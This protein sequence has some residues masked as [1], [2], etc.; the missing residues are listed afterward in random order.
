MPF[1][2]G[3]GFGKKDS[4]TPFA[5]FAY[6]KNWVAAPSRAIVGHTVKVAS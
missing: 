4:Q 3:A 2:P 5:A 1:E 6:R